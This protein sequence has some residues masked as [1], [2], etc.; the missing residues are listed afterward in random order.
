[1]GDSME[2]GFE[3]WRVVGVMREFEVMEMNKV[4]W[5]NVDLDFCLVD[6]GG[7]FGK[8]DGYLVGGG[9]EMREMEK[10]VEMVLVGIG[11]YDNGYL[12]VKRMFEVIFVS[13]V[14]MIVVLVCYFWLDFVV[15]G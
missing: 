3:E 14:L 10:Y 5:V 2:N 4:F 11:D 12:L 1:M 13:K 15:M 8:V 7:W 6:L 9:Y